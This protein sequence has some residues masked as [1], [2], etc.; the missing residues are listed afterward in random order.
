MMIC[1]RPWV[2]VIAAAAVLCGM[3]SLYEVTCAAPRGE[4]E[5]FGNSLQQRR[6]QINELKEVCELLKEQNALLKEQNAFLQSGR[7]Q[8]VVTLPEKPQ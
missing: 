5:P 4:Q 3:L 1:K 6:Q 8:V 2:L 7:L